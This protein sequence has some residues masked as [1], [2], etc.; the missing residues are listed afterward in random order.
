[1]RSVVQVVIDASRK[2]VATL[3]ADPTNSKRWMLDLDR[4]EPISGKPGMPGSVY[5]LV[6]KDGATQFTATVI[7]RLPNELHLNLVASKVTVDVHGVLSTL[8]DG[9][10]RLASV[11]VFT[12]KGVWNKAY[13]V[14]ARPVIHKTHRKHI[15]AFKEFAEKQTKRSDPSAKEAS[16]HRAGRR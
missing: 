14:F 6:G 3:L 11:E 9:R 15:E 12:F 2:E 10:T 8:P 13:G 5:R 7:R 4:Y 1:M 16:R